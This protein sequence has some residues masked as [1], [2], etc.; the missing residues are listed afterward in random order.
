VKKKPIQYTIR[1]I[2][3]EVNKAVRAYSA[4]E[5]CSLNK[6]V[7]ETLRKGSGVSDEQVIH[8]DLDFMAGTWVADAPCDQALEEFDR[9]D[10]GL[11]R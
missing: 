7:L 9:V 2:P 1:Q 5:G 10:Q 8:H 6:A 3:L 11:W 4:R